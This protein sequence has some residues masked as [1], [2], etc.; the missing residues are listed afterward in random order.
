MKKLTKY[1]LW[2][3]FGI[4]FLNTNVWVGQRISYGGMKSGINKIEEEKG[5]DYAKKVCK[6]VLK[7][8]YEESRF[9]QF[10]NGS[11]DAARD[12]LKIQELKEDIKGLRKELDPLYGPQKQ[13]PKNIDNILS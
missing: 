5:V 2:G 1:L 8:S 13:T 7:E 9:S 12:Y 4:C 3:V 10:L 6:F 11:D